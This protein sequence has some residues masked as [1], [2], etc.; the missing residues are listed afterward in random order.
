[1][2]VLYHPGKANIV[3]DA[4]MRL[5]MGSVAHVEEEKKEL[6]KDVHR[7]SCLG[8]FLTS[9]GGVMVHNGLQSSLILIEAHNSRYSIHPCTTKMYRD[10]HE[11]FWWNDMKSDIED[12]VAKCPNCQQVKAEHQKPGVKTTDSTK[13]YT[14]LYINEIVRLHGV[15]FS[16][17]SDRGI[18]G[19]AERTIQTLEDM[20]IA[21]VIDFKG[22]WDNHLLLVEFTY[23]NNFY[24]NIQM[25]PYEALYGRRCRSL[26]G[27]FEVGEVALIGPYSVHAAMKKIQLIKDRLKIAQSR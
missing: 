15:P 14:K 13:D 8:V 9:Y 19:Q 23:N 21:C 4:L 16:I 27:C 12:F 11:V 3:A 2:N 18:D 10:L 20:L 6:A 5:S 24:S 25:A 26:I 22:S 7:L 1:M 17:I